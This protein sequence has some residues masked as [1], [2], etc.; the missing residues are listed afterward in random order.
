MKEDNPT[1]KCKCGIEIPDKDI[2]ICN[3]TNEFG[4]EYYEAEALCKCGYLIE[5]NGWGDCNSVG[6]AKEDY[7]Q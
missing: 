3:K 7:F 5:W 2:E 4:E 6:I 1:I